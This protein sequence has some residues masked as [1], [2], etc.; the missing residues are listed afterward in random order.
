MAT[1]FFS[2]R[3]LLARQAAACAQMAADGLDGLLIFRQE[4]MY[5][6][7]GYDTAGY[8]M[9]QAMFL[10]ADG[11]CALVTR[12]ID[13]LQSQMTS[14]IKDI[15]IWYDGDNVDPALDVREMLR[16]HGM[17]GKRVGVEYHAYGLTGQRAKMV[18]AALDTFCT[19]SDASDLVRLLRLV[20][21]PAELD[22]VRK[23]GEL[24]DLVVE[25]S[26][27]HTRPGASTKAIYGEMM[28][29][30]MVN[31]G[32]PA[33]SRW[34]LGAGPQAMMARYHTGDE[35]VGE[36]DQ[37]CFEPGAAY[38]HYHACAMYNILTGGVSEKH[39]AMHTACSAA[40]EAC[41]DT[42]RPGRTVG[43][44]FAAYKRA[45]TEHGFGAEALS[46]CGYTLGA[47]YPPTWMDWPMVWAGNPQ[48]IDTGMV[49]FLHMTLF[50][51]ESGSSMCLGETA[52]VGERGCEAVNHVPREVIEA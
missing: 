7:T 51:R 40:L 50:D 29:T 28:R 16:D 5:Y 46:A 48:V 42:L 32:D 30:L 27:A 23:A 36:T 22:Y 3:E 47:M 4:S 25:T 11:R 26:I 21:S 34:P 14:I 49:F 12:P 31:G 39:R 10:S 18:D 38:R 43:D 33:A 37:V 2:E 19:L 20:K 44:V 15:R 6:L 35:I 45:F 13:R 24:C 1:I 52:I 8:T 9:F 17:E 41:Q